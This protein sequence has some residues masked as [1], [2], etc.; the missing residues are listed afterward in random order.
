[1]QA[2]EHIN[3]ALREAEHRLEGAQTQIM[4][5]QRA[6]ACQQQELQKAHDDEKVHAQAGEGQTSIGAFLGAE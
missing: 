3:S 5:L 2:Q 4:G 6:T 1:M